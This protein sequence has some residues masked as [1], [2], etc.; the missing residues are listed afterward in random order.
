MVAARLPPLLHSLE[1]APEVGV[2]GGLEGGLGLL[3]IVASAGAAG[4][5]DN[6]AIIVS[7]GAKC[8]CQPF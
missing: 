5:E 8:Q 3:G 7:D 4:D 2:A 6:H 1:V